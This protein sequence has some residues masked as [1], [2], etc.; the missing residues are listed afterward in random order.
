MVCASRI[1]A[2]ISGG[3]ALATAKEDL[4]SRNCT[5]AMLEVW[6][7]TSPLRLEPRF[8]KDVRNYT[9]AVDFNAEPIWVDPVA[10]GDG[11][12]ARRSDKGQAIPAGGSGKVSVS[13][14][15]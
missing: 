13:L 8:S 12:Q 9:A 14:S 11:C 15:G 3:V 10:S 7:G 2:L 4:N 6:A 5:L 1:A